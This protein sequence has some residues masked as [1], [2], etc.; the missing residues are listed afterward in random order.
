MLV[1]VGE[2]ENNDKKI[3]FDNNNDNTN[4]TTKNENIKDL[5]IL[6]ATNNLLEA[7]FNISLDKI[8]TDNSNSYKLLVYNNNYPGPVLWVNPKDKVNV[9]I[10]NNIN[11]TINRN[12]FDFLTVDINNELNELLWNRKKIGKTTTNINFHGLNIPLQLS[13]NNN[14]RFVEKNNTIK[15]IFEIP[16]NNFGGLNHYRPIVYGESNNQINKGLFGLIYLEGKYQERLKKNNIRPQILIYSNIAIENNE[17]I[18]LLNGQNQPIIQIGYGELQ[19]WHY[20]NSSTKLPIKLNIKDHDIIVIGKDGV[21][22]NLKNFSISDKSWD[23]E[24]LYVHGGIRLN[25]IIIGPGQRFEFFI[26]P[27]AQKK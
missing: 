16:E 18:H 27:K 21:N 13:G 12:N 26:I 2:E 1:P 11:N 7:E 6:K 17:V 15:Y 14:L 24:L 3:K 20:F 9:V 8:K 5:K 23:P 10:T 4:F 22:K 25:Y 19:V